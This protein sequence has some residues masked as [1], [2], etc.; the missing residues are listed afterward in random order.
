[1]SADTT[2]SAGLS[3]QLRDFVSRYEAAWNGRD[4]SAMVPL[5]TDDIVWADPALPE[6]ARGPAAVQ[7]FMEDSWRA[8]PD[9]VFDEPDP[10]F[11]LAQGDRV[12]WAWR[13]RGT[14]SGDRIDPPGF[15]P[16][17]RSMDVRGVDLWVMRDGRIADYQAVYDV[18]G[19][20]RQLG[21]VPEAGSGAEKAV[22]RLQ[23]LQA[24]FMRRR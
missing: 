16:T 18:N 5:V 22:V 24:R 6:P 2:A 7:Q 14:F 9:L 21:I 20:A 3:E 12:M 4:S 17:G 8:F 10:Q 13:M 15:A 23:R 11:L 1:M 19:M